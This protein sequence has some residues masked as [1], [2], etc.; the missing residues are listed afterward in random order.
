ME[1]PVF[2]MLFKEVIVQVIG[3]LEYSDFEFHKELWEKMQKIMICAIKGNF[4][5]MQW[6]DKLSSLR[7]FQYIKNFLEASKYPQPPNIFVQDIYY[8]HYSWIL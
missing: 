3:N 5:E 1:L 8:I 2:Y 4:V 6:E 7:M